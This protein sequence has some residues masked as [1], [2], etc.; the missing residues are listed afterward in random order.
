MRCESLES[1]EAA[2]V[3]GGRVVEGKRKLDAQARFCDTQTT[4]SLSLSLLGQSHAG[5]RLGAEQQLAPIPPSAP[6]KHRAFNSRI[7]GLGFRQRCSRLS[8]DCP[9]QSRLRSLLSCVSSV[10]PMP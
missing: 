7:L 8:R 9:D 3:E 2:M 4:R 6:P 1:S 5:A 10:V